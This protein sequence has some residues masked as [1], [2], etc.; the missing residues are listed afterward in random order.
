[1]GHEDAFPEPT[2]SA[3]C[4]FSQRTFA[5][6]QGTWREAPKAGTPVLPLLLQLADSLLRERVFAD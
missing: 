5:G 3:R 2:L 1:M 6:T 4:R